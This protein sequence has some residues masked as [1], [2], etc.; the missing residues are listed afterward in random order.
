L[1]EKQ[2]PFHP[3]ANQIAHLAQDTNRPLIKAA[4]RKTMSNSKRSLRVITLL[5]NNPYPL[6]YSAHPQMETLAAAGYDV[7]VICPRGGDQVSRET[8]N[9]VHVYRFRMPYFGTKPIGYMLEFMYASV[10]MAILT[11]LVWARSGLDILH[12]YN[13]PDTLFGAG[14][15]PKLL[16]KRIIY[17]IRDLSP[18]VYKSKYTSVSPALNRVL[19]W[20]EKISC[21]LADHVI[22]VN[23]SYR[24]IILGR[25]KLPI[26]RVT[27]VRH[28]PVL[29]SNYVAQPDTDLAGRAKVIFAYLGNMAKQDG[30]DHL[31]RA[32][33]HLDLT[34][35]YQ[36]WF[37][38]LIGRA[39]DLQGLQKM[40]NDLGIGN[41]TW[42]TGF[43]PE[44]KMLS[45]LSTAHI[46]VDPDPS[47][48]LNDVSTLCKLM[49]Y[50]ALGKPSVAYGLREHQVT[51]G[52]AALYAQPNDEV[53]MARQFVRLINDPGLRISLGEIGRQR[54]AKQLAW[55]FRRKIYLLY[56]AGWHRKDKMTSISG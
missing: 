40:A 46:C 42:F 21:V 37:C 36:D 35:G 54:I 2:E 24:Q 7:T 5:E 18:E 27:I 23:E 3:L 12:I 25:H 26:Q 56:M 17:H 50:M 9:G 19:I 51:A 11:L 34:F 44:D 52:E 14:I 1:L 47:N 43:I 20:L 38:V 29:D 8:I 4:K 55:S 13:P 28:G 41:R 16:G 6:D 30:V 22:V 39:D 53:D 10:I 33:H 45:Y 48:P 31:L 15:L 32:L 49:D